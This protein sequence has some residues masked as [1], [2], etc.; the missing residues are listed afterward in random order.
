[1][2]VFARRKN[3]C[4]LSE[5]FDLP[6]AWQQMSVIVSSFVQSASVCAGVTEHSNP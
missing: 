6:A 3:I 2:G 1:M 4:A 5:C